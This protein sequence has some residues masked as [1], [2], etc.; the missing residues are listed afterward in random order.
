VK[1]LLSPIVALFKHHKLKIL[2][3]FASFI[4]FAI[5]LFPFDD[6]GDMMTSMVAQMSANQVFLT[7]EHLGVNL[8]PSPAL[9]AEEATIELTSIRGLP[10]LKAEAIS[11]GISI[12]HLLSLQ[13]GFNL[14]ATGLFGGKFATTLP[15]KL[16]E[17]IALNAPTPKDATYGVD[18]DIEKVDLAQLT[19]QLKLPIPA[20]GKVSLETGVEIDPSFAKQPEGDIEVN[21]S[22][23]NIG[24]FSLPTDMG[25]VPLPDLSFEEIAAKGFIKNGKIT[26]ESAEI[27]APEDQ[28]Y[29]TL[30]GQ[31]DLGFS[32]GRGGVI[33]RLGAYDLNINL[34]V[35]PELMKSIP[36]F[37]VLDSY[38]KSESPNGTQ[39]SFQVSAS[40]FGAPPKMKSTP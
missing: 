32:K 34:R 9:E 33:P 25:P 15:Q 22:A 3:T 37:A 7:A 18:L 10:P 36:Y 30:K 12:P 19:S 21:A 40:R 39:F 4:L 5:L 14:K 27:G 24:A 2:A 26:I 20:K 13:I 1:K 31:M 16:I 29:M 6:L 8:I 35:T 17:G 11:A 38:K 28:L 23:V